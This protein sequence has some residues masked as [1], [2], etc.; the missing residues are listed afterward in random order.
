MVHS[1][2]KDSLHKRYLL[3]DKLFR[4][5]LALLTNVT[6]ADTK[7]EV[8]LLTNVAGADTK[9]EVALLTNVTGLTPRWR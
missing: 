6:G 9:M 4:H 8:A 3:L 1:L 5:R 2:L 7:M